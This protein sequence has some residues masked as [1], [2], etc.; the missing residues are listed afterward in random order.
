VKPADVLRK[1]ISAFVDDERTLLHERNFVD[2]GHT[3]TL[4][5][6]ARKRAQFVVELQQLV[7]PTQR[8]ADG[9]WSELLREA[10]RSLK[11]AVAGRNNGDAIATCRQSSA[12]IEARFD[13]TMRSPW[14]DSIRQMMEAQQCC[15]EDDSAELDQLQF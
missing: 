13:Q 5:R 7:G 14:P 1:L 6:L 9:S 11:V 12:R 8:R 10:G 15:L 4:T 3:G 2:G